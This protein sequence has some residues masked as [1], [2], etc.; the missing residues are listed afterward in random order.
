MEHFVLLIVPFSLIGVV[1]W[2]VVTALR[3]KPHPAVND[4][5]MKRR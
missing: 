2:V 5:P 4:L 3:D 1:G